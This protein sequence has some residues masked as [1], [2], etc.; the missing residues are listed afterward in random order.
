VTSDPWSH[1]PRLPGEMNAAMNIFAQTIHHSPPTT[2]LTLHL[3]HTIPAYWSIVRHDNHPPIPI[4]GKYAWSVRHVP[5]FDETETITLHVGP[6]EH[7]FTTRRNYLTFSSDFFTGVL[8]DHKNKTQLRTS[9]LPEESPPIV[10]P[11]RCHQ[12][13]SSPCRLD[14][15][16]EAL[17]PE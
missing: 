16:L 13:N 9:K 12:R 14:R 3:A 11:R 8:E 10:R 2:A 6:D 4:F 15:G 1:L 5:S 17:F 7:L